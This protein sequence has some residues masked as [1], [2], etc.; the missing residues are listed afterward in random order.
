LALNCD[1]PPEEPVP[2]KPLIVWWVMP[3]VRSIVQ[4]FSSASCLSRL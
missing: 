3:P 2:V 1:E 4:R